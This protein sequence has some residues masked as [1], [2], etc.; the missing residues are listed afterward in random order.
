MYACNIVTTHD[1]NFNERRSDSTNH[2]WS[3]GCI[4]FHFRGV[5][6]DFQ[7]S[8]PFL[9]KFLYANRIAP[10]ETPHFAASHLVLYCLSMSKDARLQ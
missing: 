4:H 3:V 8:S 9:M 7:F 10:D 6:S 2:V 1:S 5:R